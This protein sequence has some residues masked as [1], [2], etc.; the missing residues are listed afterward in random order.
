MDH[1]L[2]K[3]EVI[4]EVDWDVPTVE[5]A[6]ILDDDFLLENGLEKFSFFVDEFHVQEEKFDCKK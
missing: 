5:L 3:T 4:I 1:C 6:D 2:N